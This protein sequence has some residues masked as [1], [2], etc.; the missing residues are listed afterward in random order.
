[1]NEASTTASKLF[2]SSHALGP[3]SGHHESDGPAIVG[4][5]PGGAAS[6][7]R[8]DGQN[9]LESLKA[10]HSSGNEGAHG[11]RYPPGPR[12]ESS[13]SPSKPDAPHTY[14]PEW[15]TRASASAQEAFANASNSRLQKYSQS[16]SNGYAGQSVE[17]SHGQNPPSGF[18]RQAGRRSFQIFGTPQ[19]GIIGKHKPREIVRIDRDYS[20]GEICQFWSGYPME[21]EGRVS[22]ILES[23]ILCKKL[24]QRLSDICHATSQRHEC[25][26]YH[27][28]ICLQ[29][30]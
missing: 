6:S 30:I 8:Y 29:P 28:R 7:S 14:D 27:P 12:D 2:N 25:A 16:T 9:V 4:G 19:I 5:P 20:D 23:P 24:K 13:H 21:L 15:S 3:L 18:S 17:Y 11:L 1:M 22:Y 26:Q 10:S